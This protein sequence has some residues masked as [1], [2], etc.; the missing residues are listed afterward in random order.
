MLCPDCR[1]PQDFLNIE[2]IPVNYPLLRLINQ[3]EIKE[4][5]KC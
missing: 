5:P 2:E 4:N 1:K 3:P